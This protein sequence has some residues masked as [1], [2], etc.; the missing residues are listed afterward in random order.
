MGVPPRFWQLQIAY[1]LRKCLHVQD[2]ALGHVVRAPHDGLCVSCHLSSPFPK[3][4]GQTL[5]GDHMVFFVGV[6]SRRHHI[7]V[8]DGTRVADR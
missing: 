3:V 2:V 8:I 1:Q 6:V 5:P 4:R 7:Q